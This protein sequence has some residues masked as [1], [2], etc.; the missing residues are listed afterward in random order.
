VVYREAKLCGREAIC[1]AQEIVRPCEQ[2][3]YADWSE[4]YRLQREID[5]KLC[6]DNSTVFEGV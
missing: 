4:M 1:I 3:A 2:E 6:T 5:E